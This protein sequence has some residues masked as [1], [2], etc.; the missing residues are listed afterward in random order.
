MLSLKGAAYLARIILTG[1]TALAVSGCSFSSGAVTPTDRNVTL[2]KGP[3]VEEIVTIFDSALT[4]LRGKIPATVSFG[5]GDVTDATGKESYADGATGKFVSQGA[6][7]MVQS[8]LFQAGAKVVNRRDAKISIME[9]Q[10]GIRNL[11][12]QTPVNFFISGTINSLDFIPGGGASLEVG[13]VGPRY[14]QNRILIG[15]DLALTDSFTGQVLASIP[16]QKQIFSR[17]IGLSAGRFFA[18]TLVSLD[19]GGQQREAVH[20]VLRQ[21]LNLGTF[22]LLGL[23]VSEKTFAQCRADVAEFLGKD[24]GVPNGSRKEI[25]AAMANSARLVAETKAAMAAAAN[26]QQP[27]QKQAAARPNP[28]QAELARIDKMAETASLLA[29]KSIALS[30]EAKGEKDEKARTKKAAQ[31]L[32]LVQQAG[33][34]LREAAK[35]GLKGA[36]G[37]AVA[38]VVQRALEMAIEVNDLKP[39]EQLEEKPAPAAA[40][41]APEPAPAA[42]APAPA[43]AND[44]ADRANIPGTPEYQR[45]RKLN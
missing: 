42:P 28:A 19:V 21:M 3:P 9:T 18:D 1:A 32:S 31:A 33:K 35:A 10:W 6:G 15:L 12:D 44:N 17:E 25:R 16:L 36:K 43:P 11:R 39:P 14:R 20:F 23:F 26:P 40:Q 5:V 29:A 2:P 38:I 13:G 22:E 45:A 41:A 24:D 37:D 4:C 30:E 34:L 7:E 27:Q 8:A